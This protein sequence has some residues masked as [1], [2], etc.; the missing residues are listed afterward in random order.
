[1]KQ[2]KKRPHPP[3]EST[4]AAR[5]PRF[6]SAEWDPRFSRV[7]KRA[8]KA[9][10]DERF[11]GALKTNPGFR[12]SSAPV[13]RF[14]RPKREGPKLDRA[15]REIAERSDDSSSE[16]EDE[17]KA[18]VRELPPQVAGDGDSSDSSDEDLE[19]FPQEDD[20]V[21]DIPR[22]RATRRLAVLGLDWSSTR[23][24]DIFASL[25]SF[26]PAGKRVDFVEVHPS[27]FG[28]ERLAIE[29]K[30]GPQVVPQSDIEVVQRAR[31][32]KLIPGDGQ[33]GDG[34]KDAGSDDDSEESKDV[35]DDDIDTSDEEDNEEKLW[36]SQAALRKYEEERL[37]YYYGVVQFEDVKAAD[38]VYEQCDGVDYA[39]SGRSFDLR[40]I[41]DDMVIE[42]EPREKADKLPEG[43]A[44][45]N[46]TPSSLNNSNVKL[47][48][49]ADDPERV[50]LKK[51]A[52]GKH[53]LDEEN[54]KAYLADSSSED[55]EQKASA[56]DLEKKRNLL[57]GAVNDEQGEEEED[58]DME[59]SFEPG[60]LEKGEDIV[61]R[62]LEKNEHANETPWEA[63]LRRMQERKAEK[64]RKRKQGFKGEDE[65]GDENV[66][67]ENIADNPTFDSDTFFSMDRDF[68]EAEAEQKRAKQKQDGRKNRSRS[69][70]NTGEAEEK[71]IDAEKQEAELE[72]LMMNAKGKKRSSGRSVGEMLA[73]V[74]SD[75]EGEGKSGRKKTR[76]RRH[77]QR[78]GKMEEEKG[79]RSAMETE[80]PRF[81]QVFES[82][83]YAMDPTHP[84]FKRDETTKRILEEKMR[85][86]AKGKPRTKAGE[87]DERV[88]KSRPKESK[89]KVESEA[90]RLVASI[91][92]RAAAKR[93]A[94]RRS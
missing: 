28:L 79:K 58:M 93:K 68:D 87:S 39:Q 40:F 10:N 56:A 89:P 25:G 64:R 55:D 35:S 46:V 37:K 53:E 60:M 75:D 43:Y 31:E 82:H 66:V 3:A 20:K 18:V 13:D 9:I 77:K 6:A 54:L 29:A 78:K 30:L 42:T 90:M 50:I 11:Q 34:E 73:A 69:S 4:N 14:G 74:D 5:D 83:L 22:G 7:P 86:T 84:K 21:E 26:C 17:I 41:P 24:V 80:D 1:M 32:Q 61:K 59:V 62:K 19:D 94:K 51:K 63:R 49:D 71:S 12:A 91:K 52:V 48:W 44:P 38:A 70:P 16:S 8:K 45:P 72:L 76:G 85:R 36:K 92:A 27:K 33:K 81:Q 57:L 15:L 65:E 67:A 2:D 88:Q 47:S 23:A